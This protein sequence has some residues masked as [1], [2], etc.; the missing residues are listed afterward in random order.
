MKNAIFVIVEVTQEKRELLISFTMK[1]SKHINSYLS[2]I[3][4]YITNNNFQNFTLYYKDTA[5]IIKTRS[6]RTIQAQ[7]SIKSLKIQ[8]PIMAIFTP[9]TIRNGFLI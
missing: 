5:G 6:S 7:L 9:A 4:I 2:I 3:K 8:I 1:N